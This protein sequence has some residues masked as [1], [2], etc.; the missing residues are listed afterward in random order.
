MDDSGD[1]KNEA[2]KRRPRK[3][4]AEGSPRY[5]LAT[6][7]G[8]PRNSS[9]ER[10][11]RKLCDWNR[12]FAA[13]LD[14][15]TCARLIVEK[16]HT[17]EELTAF[18]QEELKN[19]ETAFAER[20]RHLAQ[21]PILPKCDSGIRFD[22]VQFD[23]WVTFEGYLFTNCSFK[24]AI[25]SLRANANFRNAT[26]SGWNSFE[27]A[28]FSGRADFDGTSFPRDTIV[29]I[30]DTTM[31][32][33]SFRH[34]ASFEATFAGNVKFDG[35]TTFGDKTS[36]STGE[37]SFRAATFSGEA[38]VAIGH[39]TFGGATFHHG[40]SFE[41][42]TFAGNVKYD[43]VRLS[44]FLCAFNCEIGSRSS[45]SAAPPRSRHP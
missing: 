41:K 8:E 7:Y 25:F 22:G 12:Y 42:A 14:N 3:K 35:R 29:A 6:L 28:I 27:N 5:L 9:D 34:G 2:G 32:G 13:E 33:M 1:R 16:R 17:E 10:W 38:D 44:I 31:R 19:I 39:T 18:S 21:K 36:P 45:T 40:A 20:C 24:D 26:F 23:E 4:R 11:A 30:G 37:T 15:K 43:A